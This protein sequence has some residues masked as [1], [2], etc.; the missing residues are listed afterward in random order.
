MY[1]IAMIFL[2]KTYKIVIKQIIIHLQK[3]I[4]L[5]NYYLILPIMS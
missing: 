5:E 1:R 4:Q 3:I 2:L